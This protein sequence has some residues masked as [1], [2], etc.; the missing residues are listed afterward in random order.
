MAAHA[1][2]IVRISTETDRTGLRRVMVAVCAF[3]FRSAGRKTEKI[4]QRG[5]E[6]PRAVQKFHVEEAEPRDVLA[7]LIIESSWP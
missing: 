7:E 4:A 5:E 6:Y 2:G 3:D 1:P